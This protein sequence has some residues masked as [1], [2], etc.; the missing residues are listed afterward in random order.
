V[1]G[2]YT[3]GSLKMIKR[4]V[5]YTANNGNKEE[6]SVFGN[7]SIRFHLDRIWDANYTAIVKKSVY[8]FPFIVS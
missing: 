3:T 5:N 1:G 8:L 4:E 7:M 6:T 2:E